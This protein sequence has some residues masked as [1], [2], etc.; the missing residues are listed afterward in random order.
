[1]FEDCL[2]VFRQV[3]VRHMTRDGRRSYPGAE[4]RPVYVTTDP[5]AARRFKEALEDE[6]G[7]PACIGRAKLWRENDV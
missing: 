3:P 6:G 1:M 4:L 2:I 7:M 5:L